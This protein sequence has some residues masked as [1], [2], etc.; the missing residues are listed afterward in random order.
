MTQKKAEDLVTSLMP[1]AEV[2]KRCLLVFLESMKEAHKYGADKWGAY[3]THGRVRLLV[4]SLIALTIHTRG[5]WVPLDK[6]HL[7][8]S[9]ELAR[10]LRCSPDWQWDTGKDSEYV[11]VPSRNG[12]YYPSEDLQ[13]WSVLREGHFPFIGRVATKYHRL[14]VTSQ[15]KH[16]PNLLTYL[17]HE[18]NTTTR[19]HSS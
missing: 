2:R 18:S 13:L 3:C 1:D 8:D 5:V 7:E 11:A 14:K 15:V 17:R 12:Y 10:L 19:L 16:M 4:G 6:Q 9:Q